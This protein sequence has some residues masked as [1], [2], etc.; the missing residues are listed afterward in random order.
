ML[1]VLH[2]VQCQVAIKDANNTV[3]S[4]STTS[5]HFIRASHKSVNYSLARSLCSLTSSFAYSSH[6][7]SLYIIAQ[8]YRSSPFFSNTYQMVIELFF[9]NFHPYEKSISDEKK[10]HSR[11]LLN[12]SSTYISNE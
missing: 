11:S 8:L 9:Y 10:T 6:R 1:V 12:Y 5:S 4:G 7:L 3:N 2:M